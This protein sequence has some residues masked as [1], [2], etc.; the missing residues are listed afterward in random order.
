MCVRINGGNWSLE[1][2]TD[3]TSGLNSIVARTETKSSSSF[4][5]LI[6]ETVDKLL[7]IQNAYD[8][9]G[10]HK[11]FSSG[12]TTANVRPTFTGTSGASQ[13]VT[14]YAGNT[15]LGSVRADANG[16]WS[17]EIGKDLSSGLNSVTAGPTPK[18]AARSMS[19]L[20]Q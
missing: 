20:N 9:V 17:L 19:T 12:A 11:T 1:I 7:I 4:V 2:D 18:Q 5:V 13:L 16:N 8:N 6:Q 10:E 3:L 15:V 14:L